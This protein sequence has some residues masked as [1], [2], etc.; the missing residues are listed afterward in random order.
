MRKSFVEELGAKKGAEN[1]RIFKENVSNAVS[2]IDRMADVMSENYETYKK[3]LELTG[4]SDLAARVAGVAQNSSMS[5]WLTDKMNEELRK[6]GDARSASDIFNMSE[7]EVKKFGENSAI[8]KL[9]DEWQKNNKKIKKENLD[10]YA[11]AI[12]NAKGYAEKVA[13]I[14]RELEREIAAIKEMTGGDAPT[15]AQQSQRTALTKNATDRANKKIADETWNNF[16]ATEEWGRIFADLDRISTGTLTR[17]LAK[18]RE[19]AP[20]LNGSVESTKAVYEAIDKVTNVVNGRN[21]F[22]AISESLG[23]RSALRGYYKQAEKK[24]NLVANAELSKL[25]G[26]KL[27]S[28]VTKDQIKDGMKNESEN[29][30][31]AIGKVVDGLQTFQNGLDL[32][33]GVFDS[34]GME[35]A[36]NAVGDTAGVL[37]GAMQGASALSALGPWGMAAGAGLGLISGLAQLHDKRLERQIEKLREDVQAIEANTELIMQARERTFGYDNGNLRRTYSQQYAANDKAFKLGNVTFSYKSDAQKA[38]YEYYRKNSAGSG[39]QQQLVNLKAERED[40][41][42]M[43]DAENDKKKKSNEA[44]EEYKQKIAELDNQIRYFAEDIANELWSI[45]MKGWADQF[46]D[47]FMTAFENGENM[48][49]AFDDTAKSIMQSVV[50]EMLKI[51]IIEPMIANLRNK[52]FG[53][54]DD[55]GKFHAGVVS[56]DELTSDPV[57]ASQ[58]QAK[59]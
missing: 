20:T 45:D 27:G 23:N 3:W 18:L 51:G 50:K 43:Y 46:S 24:G 44:L 40:Y 9:W 47:A 49:K 17:M 57:R 29:F 8:F 53:Y 59:R 31:K 35:G 42:K 19:I 5:G 6:S 25:L 39:Y 10:L 4:D 33:S 1:L 16:K 55:Y 2:E 56:T 14:N 11:E 32:V 12:K 58:F 52:L 15:E 21:P 34:L 7:S 26:V 13:D 28:T 48:M 30:K 36:A 37:G 22:K 41:M 38:M 54:T